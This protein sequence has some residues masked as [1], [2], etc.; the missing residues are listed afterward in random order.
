[1]ILRMSPGKVPSK[2]IS[3]VPGKIVFGVV[4][5]KTISD[6]LCPRKIGLSSSYLSP[7]K[8]IIDVPGKV[9]YLHYTTVYCACLSVVLVAFRSWMITLLG[10]S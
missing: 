9:V 10:E 4:H 7:V 8:T 1:M 3:C 6:K 2:T 5:R